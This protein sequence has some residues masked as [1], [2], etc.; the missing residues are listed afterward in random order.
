MTSKQDSNRGPRSDKDTRKRLLVCLGCGLFAASL[1]WIPGIKKLVRN[2]EVMTRDTLMFNDTRLEPRDDLVFLGIDSKSLLAGGVSEEELASSET[3]QRMQERYPWDRRV[4]A[5][6]IDKLASAGAK[7]IVL[8]IVLAQ[9]SS[10]E[11]DQALAEAIARH[12]DK[13]VLT[14][15]FVPIATQQGDDGMQVLEPIEEFL[16][17]L[18]NETGFGYANFWS[19]QDDGVIRYAHFQR[20]L[21]EANGHPSHPDE[22]VFE[23]I[24]AVAARKMG[25]VVPDEDRRFRMGVRPKG[26]A[27][28]SYE[29]LS[30]ATIFTEKEWENNYKGGEF[31]RDK[32]VIIGPAMPL[33]QDSHQ[34]A[35]GQVY[36]AQLHLHVIAAILDEAWYDEILPTDTALMCL[37]LIG[38]VLGFF[39]A[40]YYNKAVSL[41]VCGLVY[42][43]VMLL[44]MMSG[45]KW[46]DR[47][48]GGWGVGLVFYFEMLGMIIWQ[49]IKERSQRIQ[50]HRHLQRSMSPDVADAIVKAP[51]GYYRAASGNR[52]QVTVLFADVRGFTHRSEQQDAE[53]LVGQLN[54]YLGRMVEVIFAHGGTVDKFIGDAIMVTWGGLDDSDVSGQNESSVSSAQ[55]MLLA[56]ADL[57]AMWK[58][59]GKEPFRIGIGIHH[60]EAIVG[61]VGS[62]QRTDFTVIG[63]A[64]NLASRIEGMTKAMGVDL[65]ITSSVV[66][67][68]SKKSM[69]QGVGTIRV[70][71]REE[72]V[73]LLTP[74]QGAEG[75]RAQFQSFLEEFRKGDF[76]KASELLAS[77]DVSDDLGGL[78]RFYQ[79]Q[80]EHLKQGATSPE[81]WDGILRMETK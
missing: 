73:D 24:A 11:Q 66:G 39:C 50:L 45:V 56:L 78:V 31:F 64:V 1:W 67:E 42:T 74:Q 77:I 5:A 16:G 25:G 49:A 57:N 19:K 13:I 2:V 37:C 10:P 40:Y 60:G 80:I 71:G 47:L 70:K 63:D 18:E 79:Q 75:D 38:G 68:L 26:K 69:W 36:G 20:T 62:D 48:F 9:Q 81:D 59:A 53:E 44:L 29:P 15:A 12:R 72:G 33:F 43:V 51:D 41:S 34:T 65:L 7:V 14:S 28:N 17:P 35:A 4:Y 3:L 27:V 21:S 55:E 23:S 30:V 52:R 22:P 58:K 46:I 32:L 54:E 8:D 6:V 76:A 61:E